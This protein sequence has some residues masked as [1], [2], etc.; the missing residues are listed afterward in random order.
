MG[1]LQEVMRYHHYAIRTEGTY[2]K[3]KWYYTRFNGTLH[4]R[5]VEIIGGCPTRGL[6]RFFLSPL[7]AC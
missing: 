1:Q 6:S 7:Q 3:W 2:V 4:A 5:E